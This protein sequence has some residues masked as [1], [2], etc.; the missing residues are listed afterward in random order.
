MQ[1]YKYNKKSNERKKKG[2]KELNINIAELEGRIASL[3]GWATGKIVV[4][5]KVE[6]AEAATK[7]KNSA[8]KAIRGRGAE[9][10]RTVSPNPLQRTAK[11]RRQRAKSYSG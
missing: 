10:R 8:T 9:H 5:S 6:A 7:N 3:S 2:K 4:S 11:A 1:G